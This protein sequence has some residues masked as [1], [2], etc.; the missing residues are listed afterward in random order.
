MDDGGEFESGTGIPED[1]GCPVCP[2]GI[3]EPREGD[4]FARC[5]YCGVVLSIHWAEDGEP[6]MFVYEH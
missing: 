6:F 1:Y 3:E 2:G 4:A 5:E